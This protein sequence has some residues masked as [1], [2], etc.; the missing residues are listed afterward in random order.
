MPSV[1]I[2]DGGE[3]VFLFFEC[4]NCFS[5]FFGVGFICKQLL[6]EVINFCVSC[7]LGAFVS[8]FVGYSR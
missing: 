1:L 5:E 3:D 6:F 2:A 4:F 7:G 8:I